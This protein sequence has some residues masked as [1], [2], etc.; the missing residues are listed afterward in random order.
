VLRICYGF[1]KGLIGGEFRLE[2]KRLCPKS[3]VNP[4]NHVNPVKHADRAK[5]GNAIFLQD[6]RIS[7]DLHHS[8]EP[9]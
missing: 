1:D 4:D 6:Y 8:E 5:A 2:F 7:V 9:M 3:H